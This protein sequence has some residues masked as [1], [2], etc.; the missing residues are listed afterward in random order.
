MP[1]DSRSQW[2]RGLRLPS[3][4]ARLLELWVRIP[5]G[6]WMS[7]CCECCVLSGRGLC[8]G[9]I[10]HPEESYRLWCF[11]YNREDSIMR[12]P[13]P[14]RGCW[15]TKKQK[16]T[17][18][19]TQITFRLFILKVKMSSVSVFWARKPY[20]TGWGGDVPRIRSLPSLDT[21][22]NSVAGMIITLRAGWCRVRT[23]AMAKGF[24]GL[25]N[26]TFR[27]WEISCTTPIVYRFFPGGKPGGR[28]N[29]PSLSLYC[30]N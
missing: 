9:L 22:W 6:S 19:I 28:R 12:R 26:S 4:A 21:S 2:P 25:Q 3:A 7:L 16:T 1:H 27:L 23:A 29:W 10:P 14:T 17:I 8:D 15:T 11:R 5:P 20:H 24:S 30:W 18:W 13:W